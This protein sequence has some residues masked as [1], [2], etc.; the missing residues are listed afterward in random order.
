MPHPPKRGVAL[1]E[2][3]DRTISPTPVLWWLGPQAGFILRFATITFYLDP[4]LSHA[5]APLDPTAIRHADMLLAT[6][7]QSIHGPTIATILENSRA[8]KL[9][10]PKSAAASAHAQGIPYPRMTTTDADLRIEYFKDNLYG[11]VYAIPSAHPSL[12]WTAPGGYP[13]LGYLI[14]FGRWT[15][16]HAGASVPYESL[17]DRLRPFN[18]T[19]ALLPVGET[20]FQIQE[21]ADLADAIAAAWLVPIP[22]TPTE[23]SAAVTHMLGHRPGQQFKIFTAAEKW[24]VPEE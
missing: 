13:Y 24:T 7:A 5:G 4:N 2:D 3:I 1:I 9:I 8:S 23:E 10:L 6:S 20:G 16:Y 12:D 21:A 15:I 19:V 14:R 17:A 11:R 22:S 18:V